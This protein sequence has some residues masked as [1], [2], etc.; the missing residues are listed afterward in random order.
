MKRALLIA[1]AGCGFTPGQQA[2]AIDS[3]NSAIDG[4]GEL[5]DAR[6]DAHVSA[7]AKLFLDGPSTASFDVAMCPSSYTAQL[8]ATAAVSRYRVAPMGMVGA[9]EGACEADHPGWTHLLVPD[10]ANEGYQMYHALN[11]PVTFWVGAV[12]PRNQAHQDDGWVYLSGAPVP[13][14]AWSALQPNDDNDGV[15]DNEQNFAVIDSGGGTLNDS[16]P[17]YQ[18][19]GICECDGIPIPATVAGYLAQ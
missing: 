17:T 14:A 2:A 13:T 5:V 8:P 18:F 7:D 10:V 11:Q 1:M 6:P 15:E 9:V 4:P 3:R 19:Y 16:Q 12:Q